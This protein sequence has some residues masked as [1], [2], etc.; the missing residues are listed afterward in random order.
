MS[1]KIDKLTPEQEASIPVYR[2]K[3]RK[4]ALK[5]GR[6]NRDKVIDS[7]DAAYAAIGSYKPRL[8]F[9]DSPYTGLGKLDERLENLSKLG[10]STVLHKQCKITGVL[11]GDSWVKAFIRFLWI[12]LETQLERQI[13]RELYKQL[14]ANLRQPLTQQFRQ[15]EWHLY[16]QMES[17]LYKQE[18]LDLL[19]QINRP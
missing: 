9:F 8:I 18:Y 14:D 2:E 11:Q 4:I 19:E 13:S 1:S 15:I 12:E 10:V 5:T 3:W 7:I 6:C 16:R 17:E